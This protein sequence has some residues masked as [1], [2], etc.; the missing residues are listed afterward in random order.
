L[1]HLAVFSC[2]FGFL[3]SFSFQ[4]KNQQGNTITPFIYYFNLLL[5]LI[6]YFVKL[7]QKNQPTKR[8]RPVTTI[9]LRLIQL[10]V[11]PFVYKG[12]L[13]QTVEAAR[14]KRQNP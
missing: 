7:K 2:G 11:S 14:W 6:K 4:I 1:L 9:V 12:I 5:V 3:V 10:V 8:K 13:H